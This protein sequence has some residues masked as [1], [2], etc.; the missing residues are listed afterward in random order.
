M[1]GRSGPKEVVPV[2]DGVAMSLVTELLQAQPWAS[3]YQSHRS[4]LRTPIA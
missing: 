4:G 2:R 1:P 3:N